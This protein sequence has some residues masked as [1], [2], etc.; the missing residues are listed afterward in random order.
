MVIEEHILVKADLEKV[1]KVFT[2]LTCWNNW[3]SVIRD[4]SCD[5]QC[6][7]SGKMLRCQFRP[8]S[9][10]MSVVI[11]VE[12]VIP[13]QSVIWSVR[14]KGFLAYHEFLFQRQKNRVLVI[15]R[16]TFSGVLVRLL[17]FLLPRKR[18]RMLTNTFLND[19]KMASESHS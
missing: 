3:N 19:L 8:L 2:D 11:K 12:Q 16:E 7:A 4:V 18:I 15:S 5:D 17:K 14:K 6:I 9:F 10:P 1:W 13:T